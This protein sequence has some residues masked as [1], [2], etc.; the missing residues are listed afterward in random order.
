MGTMQMLPAYVKAYLQLAV[1]FDL[2]VRMASQE[3]LSRMG[4]PELRGEFAAQGIISPDYFVYDELPKEKKGVRDFWLGI[5]R[6]IK[7]GVTELYIHAGIPNDELKAITGSWQTRSQEFEVFTHDEEMKQIVADQKII[8]I[9][10]RPLRDLQRKE[11]L[12]AKGH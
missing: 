1:E 4:H 9:G 2:P 6:N 10:Y 8:L 7:P 3:T 12:A 11:R 5:V